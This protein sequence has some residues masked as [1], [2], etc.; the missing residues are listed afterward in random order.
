M[1]QPSYTQ[2]MKKLNDEGASKLTSRYS[3]V[4]ATARRARQI[5]DIVNEQ[6]ALNKE[7]DKTGEKVISP[8]RLRQAS[9]LNERLKTKK[10]TS[11]AVDEIYN[12]KILMSEYYSEEQE[13]E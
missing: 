7:A 11:I 13:Q 6:A 10:P 9:E 1:L 3:I 2:L 5:I 4:I 12:G 8:A